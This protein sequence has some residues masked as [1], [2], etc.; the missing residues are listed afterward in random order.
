ML[1]AWHVCRSTHVLTTTWRF[2]VAATPSSVTVRKPSNQVYE[3]T[4]SV[5]G[6]SACFV[7][8]H[9]VAEQH[10]PSKPRSKRRL[11]YERG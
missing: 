5:L 2:T 7:L 3:K 6:A 1:F 9:T 8:H 4:V 11:D 10:R